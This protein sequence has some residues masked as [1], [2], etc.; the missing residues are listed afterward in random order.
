MHVKPIQQKSEQQKSRIYN[1]AWLYHK[2][3]RKAPGLPSRAQ[4]VHLVNAGE[5]RANHLNETQISQYFM[6]VVRRLRGD[7]EEADDGAAADEDLGPAVPEDVI[8]RAALEVAHTSARRGRAGAARQ[9]Q[10][11]PGGRLRGASDAEMSAAAQRS[12]VAAL[13]QFV[14]QIHTHE[15]ELRAVLH[16]RA[17]GDLVA[18]DEELPDH[19]DELALETDEYARVGSGSDHGSASESDDEDDDDFVP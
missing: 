16:E 2:Y 17:E 18:D 10:E 4:Q 9:E 14:N 13:N 15:G 3:G 8:Q 5:D 19:D 7:A 6:M 1:M 11:E 12:C